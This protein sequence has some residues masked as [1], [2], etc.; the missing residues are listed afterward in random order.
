[1]SPR[2]RLLVLQPESVAPIGP[3][4]DWLARAG[5]D[6][7][8]LRL[9]E[10]PAVPAALGDHVGLLV[11]GGRMGANDDAEHRW[12]LPAKALIVGTVA[13]GA[14]FLGICL[15]HQLAAVAMGGQVARNPH[16]P[17]SHLHPWGPTDAGAADPL[18]RVLP[19]GTG[20]LHHNNDVVV[21]LPE[22]ATSLAGAPDGTV[23]A[24]RFGPRAWGVQ[25]HPEAEVD[26]VVGWA[27]GPEDSAA[28][29]VTGE[30][31]RRQDELHP[32]WE[33]LARRFAR[34]ALAT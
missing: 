19:A 21:R 15:G 3:F 31:R 7:D 27:T 8:V 32:A 34:L 1:M 23:Q 22:G 10:G 29:R 20:V 14:P 13:A 17:S 28:H 33:Q 24:A 25:F 30:L 12:I 18:T 26:T 16:G 9:D 2:P 6:C 11:T 4:A 5:L